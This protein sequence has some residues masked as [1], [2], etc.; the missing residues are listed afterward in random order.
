MKK[1]VKVPIAY[2]TKMTSEELSQKIDEEISDLLSADMSKMKAREVML[3]EKD[4][5]GKI[6]LKFCHSFRSD[7]CDTM[8]EGKI[9]QGLEGSRL[10]GFIKKPSGIWAFFWV[11]IGIVALI[12]AGLVAAVL[13]SSDP[14]PELLIF[15]ALAMVPVAFVEVNLLQF[16]LAR[17]KTIN[18]Y[19]REFTQAVNTDVLGEELEAN[20]RERD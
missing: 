5:S 16:D 8:F 17:L 13:A 6:K 10:E 12:A 2:E 11:I 14:A 20:K 1:S 9:E 3:W 19:L 4:E 7:M 18:D 15:F